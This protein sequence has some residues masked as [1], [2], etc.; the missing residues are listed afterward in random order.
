[1][2]RVCPKGYT[3]TLKAKGPKTQTLRDTSKVAKPLKTSDQGFARL[4]H[5]TK[6]SKNLCCHL[7]QKVKGLSD[8]CQWQRVGDGRNG[9]ILETLRILTDL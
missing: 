3:I 5:L 2:N 8:V 4:W 9:Q 7:T 1:M 6:W